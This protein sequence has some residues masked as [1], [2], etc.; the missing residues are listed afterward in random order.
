MYEGGEIRGTRGRLHEPVR[1]G[2]QP[3]DVTLVG[4]LLGP[5]AE[6][7]A[8]LVVV[9]REAPGAALAC[10]DCGQEDGGRR[11][12]GTARAVH[13]GHGARAWPVPLMARMSPR[14]ACSASLGP[15]RSPMRVRNPRTPLWAGSMSRCE[16]RTTVR[17]CGHPRAPQRQR[18]GLHACPLGLGPRSVRPPPRSR[19]PVAAE[20][21]SGEGPAGRPRKAPPRGA[22]RSDPSPVPRCP[23]LG[24]RSPGEPRREA[25]T[26][27]T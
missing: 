11:L 1:V 19:P 24:S 26:R 4:A 25:R 6:R 2:E 14:S 27:P 23:R 16:N 18:D 5:P 12:A 21:A 7:A 15:E 9:P 3:E 10:E 8:G 13:H 20:P 17:G 22:F